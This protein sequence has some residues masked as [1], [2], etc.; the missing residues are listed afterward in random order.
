MDLI[1]VPQEK[2]VL[3]VEAKEAL[4]ESSLLAMRDMRDSNG[5]GKV[6][7]FVTTG[8]SSNMMAEC[9]GR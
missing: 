8:E 1:S 2:Y 4:L 7:A 9:F 3:I 6:Y 5:E